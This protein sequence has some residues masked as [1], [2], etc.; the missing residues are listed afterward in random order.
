MQ[1][2]GNTRHQ[3]GQALHDKFDA[4]RANVSDLKQ[5]KMRKINNI[6]DILGGKIHSIQQGIRNAIHSFRRKF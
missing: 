3:T 6:A 5:Q 4:V 2:F 1:K